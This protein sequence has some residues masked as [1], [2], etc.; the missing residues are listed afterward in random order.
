MIDFLIAGCV[1]LPAY[2]L[3]RW[4]ADHGYVDPYLAGWIAGAGAVLARWAGLRYT[5]ARPTPSAEGG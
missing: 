1:Y 3:G 5:A 2:I 4:L